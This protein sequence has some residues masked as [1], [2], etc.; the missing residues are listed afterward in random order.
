M[1]IRCLNED[2]WPPCGCSVQ[3]NK[4][5][6]Q[7][8]GGGKGEGGESVPHLTRQLELYPYLEVTWGLAPYLRFYTDIDETS[9]SECSTLVQELRYCTFILH[10]EIA[11]TAAS[12]KC[13]L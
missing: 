10:N 12:M 11:L 2:A 8:G 5:L 3:V 6:G 4:A 1:R 7:Y 13:I 9:G